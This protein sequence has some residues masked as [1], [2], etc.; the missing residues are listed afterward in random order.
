MHSF[1]VYWSLL[2]PHGLV[3]PTWERQGAAL[4]IP[5]DKWNASLS[6]ELL[7]LPDMTWMT[8]IWALCA[9]ADAVHFAE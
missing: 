5:P 2:M 9:K 3:Y 4:W 8:G 7:Y 6:D 1:V